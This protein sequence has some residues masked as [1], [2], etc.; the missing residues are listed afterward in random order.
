MGKVTGP[1]AIASAIIKGVTVV[2]RWARNQ[3]STGWSNRW[4]P[5]WVRTPIR[6][7]RN[8]TNP[9]MIRTQAVV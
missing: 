9:V 8:R 6:T 2:D 7:T 4:N 3:V 5:E 1:K